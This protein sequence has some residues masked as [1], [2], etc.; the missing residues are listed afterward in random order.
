MKPLIESSAGRQAGH[1]AAMSSDTLSCLLE[2]RSWPAFWTGCVE[3]RS[4]RKRATQAASD[5]TSDI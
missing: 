4:V 5:K 1:L 3:G 2:R